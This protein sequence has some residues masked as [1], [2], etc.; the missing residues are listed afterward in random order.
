SSGGVW[1]G[2]A[3][4]YPPNMLN[5]YIAQTQKQAGAV[6]SWPRYA[7]RYSSIVHM[8]LSEHLGNKIGTIE[9]QKTLQQP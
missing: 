9:T 6:G 7:Y 4:L 2:Y 3:A 5:Q 1:G 8:V